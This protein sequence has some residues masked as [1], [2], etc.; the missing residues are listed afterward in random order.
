MK[1][2]ILAAGYATRLYPLTKNQPRPLLKV[3]NQTIL[4]AIVEKM[5]AVEELDEMSIV[6]NDKFH[7]YFET[8]AKDA[9]YDIKL[10]VIND[11][12]LSNEDRLG[13][14]GDIHF[15]IEQAK[16]EDDLMIVAGD[17]LFGFSLVD[18]VSFYK[19]HQGNAISIYKE[20]NLKQ[21]IRGGTAD[22]DEDGKIIGF[23]EKPTQVNY[24]YAVPTFYMIQKE[25][26]PLFDAYQK[27]GHNMDANGNFIPYL[28]ENSTVYGFVFNEYYYDIGT[29][30]SYEQVQKLFANDEA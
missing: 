1:A 14:L 24:S 29:L 23:E 15:V 4:D 18:L 8:W 16:V 22:I 3:G 28:L 7:T 6:T 11:G 27:E 13:A 9:T 12:T 30:E 19:A 2:I 5:V 10:T 25:D 26:L 21:L 20:D 17:N